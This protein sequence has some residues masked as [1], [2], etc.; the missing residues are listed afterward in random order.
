MMALNADLKTS[1]DSESQ[2]EI[3]LNVELETNNGSECQTEKRH[4]NFE[5]RTRNKQRL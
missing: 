4:D 3:A 2:T 1:N 5:C